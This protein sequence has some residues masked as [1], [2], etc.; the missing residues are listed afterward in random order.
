MNVEQIKQHTEEQLQG[1]SIQFNPALPTIEP[2]SAV[3]PRS[4]QDIAARAYA[5]SHIIGI[6]Y[7][8][9]RKALIGQLEQYGLWSSVTKAEQKV[10]KTW[11]VSKQQKAMAFWLCESAQV[12]A[13]CLGLTDLNHFQ[14]CDE[15]LADRLPPNQDPTV[16]IRTCIRQPMVDIQQQV[17][18]L[19]RLHACVR[20][21]GLNSYQI[22]NHEVIIAQRRRAINWIYSG[23]DWDAITLDI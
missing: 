12:L 14:P 22:A 9:D 11:H 8:A 2:E 20:H 16:F 6:A 7:D 5:I 19:Y 17:D 1:W 13:W 3:S 10:L 4:A 18:L 15:D 21:R 23:Q